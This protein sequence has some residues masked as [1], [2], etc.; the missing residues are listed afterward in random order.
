M[1]VLFVVIVT[2]CLERG[3]FMHATKAYID[4]GRPP[5]AC[6]SLQLHAMIQDVGGTL[7]E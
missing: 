5:Q 3:D 6:L 1:Y 4:H 2:S 7:L